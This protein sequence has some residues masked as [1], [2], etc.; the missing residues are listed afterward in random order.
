MFIE[1]NDLS[2]QN[3][4]YLCALEEAWTWHKRLGYANLVLIGKF[5]KK[6]LVRAKDSK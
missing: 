1:L 3:I 4:D 5:N 6:S 2:Y